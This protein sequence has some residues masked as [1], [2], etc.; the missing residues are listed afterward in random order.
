M[1]DEQMIKEFERWVKA[2]R[3]RVWVKNV[4]DKEGDWVLM[5]LLPT[6]FKNR[7]YVIDDEYAE[8]RKAFYD[9]KKIQW[10]CESEQEWYPLSYDDFYKPVDKYR[11]KPEEPVYEYK[12]V[13]ESPYNG[14]IVT[15]GY[16]PI[17][18]ADDNWVIIPDSKR[19]M[20][21]E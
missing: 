17:D 13:R 9:G 5:P 18:E 12:F 19:E 7:V 11:I 16:Y 10:R 1:N 3:P 2:G 20:Y 8:I 6:W 15:E 4:S 14:W 21:D